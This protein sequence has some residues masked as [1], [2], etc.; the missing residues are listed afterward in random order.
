MPKINLC[1]LDNI[2]ASLRF[3]GHHLH[4]NELEQDCVFQGAGH[5]LKLLS[6]DVYEQIL[7]AD[8]H[9]DEEIRRASQEYLQRIK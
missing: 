8:D 9:S 7:I 1:A 5:L 4:Q 3:I 2:V 6:R